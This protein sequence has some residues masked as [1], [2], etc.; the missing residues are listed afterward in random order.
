MNKM[1]DKWRQTGLKNSAA[2]P[3]RDLCFAPTR[4]VGELSRVAAGN[5]LA[6]AV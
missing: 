2:P 3:K 6:I 5:A 4:L 1:L